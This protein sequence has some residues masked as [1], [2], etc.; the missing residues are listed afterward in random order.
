MGAVGE[1]IGAVRSMGQVTLHSSTADVLPDGTSASDFSDWQDSGVTERFEAVKSLLGFEMVNLA[2][3]VRWRFNGQF[4]SQFHVTVDGL[5]DKT[6]EVDIT[7]GILSQNLSN[8][9]GVAE[10]VYEIVLVDSHLL[11]GNNRATFRAM[12]TGNGGGMSLG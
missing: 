6:H 10:I 12:V 9:Q 2:I 1:I 11:S 7:V 3:T 5:I 8:A 4:I